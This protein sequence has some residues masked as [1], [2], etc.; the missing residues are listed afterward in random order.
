MWMYVKKLTHSLFT[1]HLFATN[2]IS[3][4]V[5]MSIGDILSQ[6]FERH[7]D[8]KKQNDASIHAGSRYDWNRNA[9]MFVVGAVQ[10]P[11]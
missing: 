2:V 9:K 7:H 11:L 5:L 3:S 4:G 6:E 8:Q 10:G 1:K